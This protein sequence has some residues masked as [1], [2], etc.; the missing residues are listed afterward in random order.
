M[1]WK[2]QVKTYT[3][4]RLTVHSLLVT[5]DRC[6]WFSEEIFDPNVF[7]LYLIDTPRH[8]IFEYQF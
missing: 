1:Y 5:T 8:K 3:W 4:K 6:L 2:F 7:L